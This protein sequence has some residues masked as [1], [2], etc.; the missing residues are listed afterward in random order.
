L[1]YNFSLNEI[2]PW[3][4]WRLICKLG[5][6][7]QCGKKKAGTTSLWFQPIFGLV[8]VFVGSSFFVLLKRLVDF[9]AAMR[10]LLQQDCP[11]GRTQSHTQI[12]LQ[13]PPR[14]GRGVSPFISEWGATLERF[15]RRARALKKSPTIEYF[16]LN[17]RKHFPRGSTAGPVERQ[18]LKSPSEK[19]PM[20]RVGGNRKR[21]ETV[22]ALIC[23][24]Y[25]AFAYEI[26]DE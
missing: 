9:L 26:T 23:S 17:I 19:L 7:V 5:S 16:N 3:G 24:G 1:P 15:A 20:S 13:C 6:N 14:R 12:G 2:A 21:T 18:G 8:N 11:L 4:G 25:C 10:F 22:V